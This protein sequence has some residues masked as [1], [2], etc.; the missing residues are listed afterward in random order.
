MI[1][2]SLQILFGI[3]FVVATGHAQDGEPNFKKEEYFHKVYK[4]YNEQPTSSEAWEKALSNRKPN[5]YSIQ[6]DDTL[7]DISQTFFG[8]AN[9]WPKV[10]SY[11]TEG[12][13]NPHEILPNQS[14]RFYS[15]TLAEPPTVGLAAADAK[16]ESMPEQVIEKN[17]DGTVEAIKLPPPKRASRPIVKNLPNSLPLYRLG[18]VNVPPVEFESNKPKAFP[19]PER[20]VSV[21]AT[22]KPINAVGEIVEIEAMDGQSATEYQYVTVRINDPSIKR[23]V[24]YGDTAKLKEPNSEISASIVE[25]QGEIEVHEKVNAADNLYRAMVLKTVNKVNLG[26]KLMPGNFA[27][28]CGSPA[29]V[30][31]A[32]SFAVMRM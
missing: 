7:W 3:S 21:Y 8:D 29:R 1:K 9:Y 16:T 18:G 24:A 28:V 13:L 14:L 6:A 23:L 30:C 2:R 32:P 27:L 31:R 25:I 17:E 11:N 12:I 20:Y 26:A 15:G 22:D 5:T 4:K 10:W 19:L